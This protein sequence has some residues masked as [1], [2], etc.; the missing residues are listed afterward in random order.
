[1]QPGACSS[2]SATGTSQRW[3]LCLSKVVVG[4]QPVGV[5][6]PLPF[7][8]D[9]V[10][11]VG[12]CGGAMYCYG[13]PASVPHTPAAA[14]SPAMPPPPPQ[15]QAVI[16]VLE[17]KEEDEKVLI[18]S[19]YPNTLRAIKAMLPAIGLESRNLIGS[20]NAG[21]QARRWPAPA[22]GAGRLGGGVLGSHARRLGGGFM[23]NLC[24]LLLP[25]SAKLCAA[26]RGRA[27]RDFQTDPP[28]KVFLLTHRWAGGAGSSAG[29]VPRR[30]MP[31]RA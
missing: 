15:A 26:A 22:A 16:E 29:P 24:L 5:H 18:F 13:L 4:R 6:V 9:G 20:S 17:D 25:T 31:S 28:T 11:E 23:L 27:I 19:E 2:R 3:V 21:A 30:S 7:W 8:F 10:V 14:A 12:P 1:M